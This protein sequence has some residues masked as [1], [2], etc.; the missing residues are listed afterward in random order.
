MTINMGKD[1]DSSYKIAFESLTDETLNEILRAAKEE[2]EKREDE[3]RTNA[4]KQFLDA[5]INLTHFGSKVKIMVKLEGEESKTVLV[6]Q[7]TLLLK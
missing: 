4:R 5:W 3:L 6:D 1:N 7:L 2:K